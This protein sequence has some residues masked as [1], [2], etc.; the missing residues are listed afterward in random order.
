M[1]RVLIAGGSGFLGRALSQSLV[2][3]GHEVWVLTRR[4]QTARGAP[5]GVRMLLWDGCSCGEWAKAVSEVDAVVNLSGESVGRWPWNAR[6]KKRLRDS[7]VLPGLVLAEAIRRVRWRPAVFLQA[8]GVNHYGARGDPATEST[9][10]G[11][12]FLARLTCD[13]EA[14]TQA[15]EELGLRR[16]VVRLAVVLAASEGM[17]PRIALPVHLCLGGPIGSG[18][19]TMPWI[20]VADAVGAMRF[21]LEHPAARGPFN[22]VAP[23]SVNNAEFLCTLARVLHRPFWLPVPSL[24]LRLALGEMSVLLL[25]GRPVQPQRLLELGYCFRFA[26]LEDALQNIYLPPR[27][28]PRRRP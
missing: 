25:E 8:S 26:R 5:E 14:S 22:L 27:H 3:D 7:R 24:P 11:E 18:Q 28:V 19:Q 21:L 1:M 12:D 13:W 10:P 23:H 6:R 17:L 9:P 16:V 20:H 15:V 4:Q 2:G